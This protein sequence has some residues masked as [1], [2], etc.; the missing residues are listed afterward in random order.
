MNRPKWIIRRDDEA[1]TWCEDA[2]PVRLGR[3]PEH[4]RNE[5]WERKVAIDD[6][7]KGYLCPG[8]VEHFYTCWVVLDEANPDRD[9][10]N[11][12]DTY[13]EA[14]KDRDDM[15]AR[16]QAEWDKAHV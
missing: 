16:E 9:R 11:V 5:P 1:V 14:V 4:Q 13:K 8:G 15:N 2:H 10:N 12:L 3:N 6:G 7:R